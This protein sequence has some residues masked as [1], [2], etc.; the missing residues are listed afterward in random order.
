M[1]KLLIVDDEY[2]VIEGL[3]KLVDWKKYGIHVIGE[4]SSGQEGL[5]LARDHKP[6]FVITDIKMP[7]LSGLDMMKRISDFNPKTRFLVLSGYDDFEW[8]KRAFNYGAIDYLLKPVDL[9]QLDAVL[10]KAVEKMGEESS[11][12]KRKEDLEKALSRSISLL[13]REAFIELLKGRYT[14]EKALE[15]KLGAAQL[16][17]SGEPCT[18]MLLKM[19]ETSEY[20]GTYI[21]ELFK[22]LTDFFEDGRW[23]YAFQMSEEEIVF[24]VNAQGVNSKWCSLLAE[25]IF[26]RFRLDEAGAVLGLGG[27]YERLGRIKYS[28]IE[29][30]KAVEYRYLSPTPIVSYF[31][32]QKH[33]LDLEKVSYPLQFVETVMEGLKGANSELLSNSLDAYFSQIKQK[34]VEIAHFKSVMME[35]LFV[36]RKELKGMN[37][38]LSKVFIDEFE[39]IY[40]IQ[41]KSGLEEIWKVVV[42]FIMSILDFIEST[43]NKNNKQIIKEVMKLIEESFSS[44]DLT[45]NDVAEKIYL[46]PNYVSMLIKKET[47]QNFSEIILR[48]RIEKAKE[49]LFDETL[50]TYEIAEKVGYVDQNYFFKAFR[51]VVGM[52]PGEFRNKFCG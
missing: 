41:K 32:I 49:L 17:L 48:K 35:L 16:K 22:K 38:D 50:K 34:R 15:E 21:K 5:S 39:D 14:S 52:T 19:K 8:A 43:A 40:S 11:G 1:Y 30:E 9:E 29:A 12:E 18:V 6:D 36:L 3:L 33:F 42:Q 28:F 13:K 27:E 26:L 44:K 24:L 47:G 20:S 37:I 25:N 2:L 51:K 23:G 45:L 10:S 7:G 46:T 31:D 4:A